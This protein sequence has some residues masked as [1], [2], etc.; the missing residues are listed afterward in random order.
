MPTF[1]E[2][3]Q[4]VDEFP[5]AFKP[6]STPHPHAIQHHTEQLYPMQPNPNYKQYQL[7]QTELDKAKQ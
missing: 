3:D 5:D 7:S 6:L 2:W 4:L 1:T